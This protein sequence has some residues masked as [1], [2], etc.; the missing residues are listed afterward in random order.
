MADSSQWLL[1]AL[2]VL[3]IGLSLVVGA[4]VLL[5][6]RARRR[7]L[8][9]ELA[10]SPAFADDRAHNQIALARSEMQ[11]LGREGF[12]LTRAEA[13]LKQA[14]AEFARHD[15]VDAVRTARRVHQLLV[16]LRADRARTGG[17]SPSA[18]ASPPIAESPLPARSSP[19]Q[20]L[21]TVGA[22]ASD[23]AEAPETPARPP[24][25]RME[26]HFQLSLLTEEI[27]RRPGGA[28]SST[29]TVR[30]GEEL[31]AAAQ[32]SYAAGDYTEAL[33]LALRGRRRLGSPL[34]TLPAGGRPATTTS[35]RAP[36]STPEV[37][38]LGASPP[39][40]PVGARC[41]GCGRELLPGDQF[42]RGCGRSVGTATCPRCQGPIDRNDTFCGRCGAPLA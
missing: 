30:E 29:P 11:V 18:A 1:V 6:L 4:F 23:G 2:A 42:C 15:N 34:E 31:R 32:K 17:A 10:D 37:I 5:R 36:P 20:E 19:P 7:G 13:L 26:A 41:P 8:K 40:A 22:D 28:A 21:P 3:S 12:D 35:P 14:E 16:D 33:R 25:N 9:A 24:K 38:G 39:E 27:A